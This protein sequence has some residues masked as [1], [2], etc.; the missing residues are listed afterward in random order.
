MNIYLINQDINDDYDTFNS[1]IV[2]ANSSEEAQNMLPSFYRGFETGK[3][4]SWTS[5]KNA[6]VELIGIAV[7]GIEIGNILS[8]FNAG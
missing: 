5:P 8:S 3:S 6:S 4:G 2:A 7:E 1:A